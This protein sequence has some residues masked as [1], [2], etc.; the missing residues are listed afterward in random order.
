M[1]K[2]CSLFDANLPLNQSQDL[3]GGIATKVCKT[4]HKRKPDN[5]LLK[6]MEGT[7]PRETLKSVQTFKT[8]SQILLKNTPRT[9]RW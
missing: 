4:C 6:L 8:I 9:R 7:E 1:Y 5:N 3:H 2:Q